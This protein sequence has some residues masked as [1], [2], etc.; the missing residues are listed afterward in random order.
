MAGA[1]AG[2]RV[3]DLSEGVA[4]PYCTKLLANFGAEV[5]K[6]E[7]PGKGDWSRHRGPF[8]HD[9]PGLEKSL[10]YAYL[11]TSKRS[12][13]LD[14]ASDAGREP[15]RRLCD[16][17]NVVVL[18]DPLTR[19]DELA[20]GTRELLRHA[21]PSLVVTAVPF[22][23]GAGPYADFKATELTLYALSGLL[24]MA[25]GDEEGRRLKAGGYQAQYMAGIQSCAM[26]LFGAYKARKTGEG[27][28]IETSLLESCSRVLSSM[29]DYVPGRSNVRGPMIQ[30]G[31]AWQASDGFITIMLYYYQ[32]ETLGKLIGAPGLARD[33]SIG[34]EVN[35]SRS[36]H[37]WGPPLETWLKTK[38]AAEAQ[39]E[40]QD[41]H[42]LFT[43]VSNTKDVVESEHLNAREFFHEVDHPLM[44]HAKYAGGPFQ[45]TGADRSSSKPAPALGEAND[46]VLGEWLGLSAD[47]RARASGL[48]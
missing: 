24:S 16:T 10:L 23:D 4:G 15:F 45:L 12:I 30:E 34:T 3:L 41:K 26:T 13:T 48:N 46:L 8:Y 11:N 47:A 20:G 43:K 39:Q 17:S 19:L 22:F 32:M 29:Q 5:I 27:G 7:K 33:P 25:S 18:S 6:I 40:G 38:T 1:L 31:A 35:L 37:L 9:E 44:G 21:N 42:L 28:F 2:L 36:R 14:L